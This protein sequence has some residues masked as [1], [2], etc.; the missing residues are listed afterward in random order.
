M[1]LLGHGI[2]SLQV[3]FRLP[4]THQDIVE[5][6]IEKSFHL[7]VGQASENDVNLKCCMYLEFQILFYIHI[8]DERSYQ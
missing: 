8:M 1:I 4:K 7:L 2:L 3:L 6:E 5:T